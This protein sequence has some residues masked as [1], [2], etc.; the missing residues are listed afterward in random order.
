MV[1]RKTNL[2]SNY[3][4]DPFHSLDTL[5]EVIIE[6]NVDTITFH[7]RG[8]HVTFLAEKLGQYLFIKTHLLKTEK[9]TPVKFTLNVTNILCLSVTV[10]GVNLSD[11]D[12]F[13]DTLEDVV[14]SVKRNGVAMKGTVHKIYYQ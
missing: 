1:I 4:K 6:F 13:S 3:G 7:P 12:T 8:W 2:K 11:E 10:S 14:T 9:V 5:S